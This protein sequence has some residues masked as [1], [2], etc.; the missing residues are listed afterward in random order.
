MSSSAKLAYLNRVISH[1]TVWIYR[2]LGLLLMLRTITEKKSTPILIHFRVDPPVWQVAHNGFDFEFTVLICRCLH[3]L[4]PRY[5]SDYIQ[6]VADS[7]HRRLRSSSSSQR[8]IQHTRLSTV[9]DCVFPLAGNLICNSLMPNVTSAPT[10]T[11]FQNRLKTYL[12]FWIISFVTVF[13]F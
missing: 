5:L 11:V 1:A 12:Y 4:A 10:L 9:G 2:L 6:R 13:D 8:V 7:N 3:G